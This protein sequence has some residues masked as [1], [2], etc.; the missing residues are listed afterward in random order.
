LA[1][2]PSSDGDVRSGVVLTTTKLSLLVTS[3]VD[4]PDQLAASEE[5]EAELT[6]ESRSPA[7]PATAAATGTAAAALTFAAA[8]SSSVGELAGALATSGMAEDMS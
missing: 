4:K 1:L 6:T 2:L 3:D 5:C 7:T 8:I